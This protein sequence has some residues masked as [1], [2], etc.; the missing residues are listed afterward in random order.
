MRPKVSMAVLNFNGGKYLSNCIRSVLASDYPD[1]DVFV[2]DNCSSDSSF[3]E[4]RNLFR[5]KVVCVQLERN[6]GC[7]EANNLAFGL[8]DPRS[9]YVGFL[10]MDTEVGTSCITDV[11]NAMEENPGVGAAQPLILDYVSRD[12]VQSAGLSFIEHA[13]WTFAQLKG[14][15]A[16]STRLPLNPVPVFAGLGAALFVRVETF[17]RIGGFDPKFFMYSDE[18][19]LCWRVW[20]SGYEVIFVPAAKVYHVLGGSRQESETFSHKVSIEFLRNRNVV[21]MLIKNWGSGY[22]IRKIPLSLAF[23][24]MRAI[25]YLLRSDPTK[26]CGLFKALIWNITNLEDTLRS[27]YSTQ[28]KVR[29]VT[30]HFIVSQMHKLT[31]LEMFRR[32]NIQQP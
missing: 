2:V 28:G 14:C 30:D 21:R 24:I 32:S 4:V 26:I 22:L 20:L 23:T 1:L 6:L 27:R 11:V 25:F 17:R 16:R 9:K 8:L 18:T 13:G 29:V 7:C 12:K 3:E 5:N 19:D 15:S 31:V 10:N